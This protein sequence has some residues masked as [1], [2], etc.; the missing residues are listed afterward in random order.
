MLAAGSISLAGRTLGKWAARVRRTAHETLAPL[1]RAG[2][3]GVDPTRAQRRRLRVVF[4]LAALPLGWASGNP[5]AAAALAFAAALLASRVV[6]WRRQRY[7]ES[8]GRGTAP[9]ARA[10]SDALSSGHS[11]RG[12]LATAARSVDG[13]MGVELRRVAAELGVGSRTD[14][15]L[16]QLRLR[17]AAHP[18]DLI[19]GAI[20]L[21]RRSGGNLAALLR[22]VAGAIEEHA[23]V[24]DE[25]R[26]ASSQARFTSAIVLAMPPCLLGLGELAD[27]GMLGRLAGSPVSVSLVAAG[28]V[29]WLAGALL[30]RRLGRL[31]V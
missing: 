17:A 29:F 6:A 22:D 20:R 25:A 28:G 27:P 12:A 13:P 24:E 8:L 9:A 1:R 3:E 21:Q 7:L 31:P 11:T 26:A 10:I 14:A 23:R 2:V 19:V 4:A 5:F 16:E 30:V 15:A 18:V